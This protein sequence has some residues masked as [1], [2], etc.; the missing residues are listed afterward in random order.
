VTEK[1]DSGFSDLTRDTS[2]RIASIDLALIYMEGARRLA[3][4]EFS[5]AGATKFVEEQKI[6][7][8]VFA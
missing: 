3:K 8:K 1:K 7:R 6:E 5:K 4:G 2:N